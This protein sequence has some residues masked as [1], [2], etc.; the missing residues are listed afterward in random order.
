[1]FRIILAKARTME[2][3]DSSGSVS[4]SRTKTA[5]DWDTIELLLESWTDIEAENRTGNTTLCETTCSV[6]L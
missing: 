5:Y 6:I 1:M 2:S 4:R 3:T